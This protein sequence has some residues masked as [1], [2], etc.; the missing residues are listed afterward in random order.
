MFYGG[1]LFFSFE[2]R[3]NVA[4]LFFSVLL[5]VRSVGKRKINHKTKNMWS[6][7]VKLWV[8]CI[9]GIMA[10]SLYKLIIKPAITDKL[11]LTSTDCLR[12]RYLKYNNAVLTQ[13]P[14]SGYWIFFDGISAFVYGISTGRVC[15]GDFVPAY[16]IDL[17]HGNK[18]KGYECV[19]PVE[20]IRN[21][22][23]ASGAI[24]QYAFVHQPTW[25]IDAIGV[26]SVLAARNVIK[27]N[28]EFLSA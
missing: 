24:E 18:V 16:V 4:N 5:V 19:A 21:F 28:R 2:L 22:F 12:I 20:T 17:L 15:E 6:Y 27:I 25:E 3:T 13:M 11:C 23:I 26:L 8:I 1:F 14:D 9:A 10:Y 7:I